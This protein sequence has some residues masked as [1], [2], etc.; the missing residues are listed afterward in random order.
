MQTPL[1]EVFLWGNLLEKVSL[2]DRG[3]VRLEKNAE[4]PVK[5]QALIFSGLKIL[6]YA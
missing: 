2:D 3:F 6:V 5:W 1:V 4:N